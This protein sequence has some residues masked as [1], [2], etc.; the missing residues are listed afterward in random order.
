MNKT[1]I[2]HTQK[3]AE[4][5]ARRQEF[6]KQV[7]KNKVSYTMIAPFIIIFFTFTVLP[8]LMSFF[9]SFTSFDML[10]AP[11]FLGL[12][13][14]IN[15]FLNDEVFLIA[16]KNTF[17]LAVIT[18]P[19]SYVLAFLFA[20]LIHELPKKIRWFMTLVFYAPSISGSAY[21]LWQLIFSSD[22][23]GVLN[24]F[25]IN[26]GIINAPILWL[27]SPQYALIILIIVQLWLSLGVT[28]LA[29]IA[30]LQTVDRTLYEAAAIDGLRNRWQEL[31]FITLPQMKSQLMFGAVMQITNALGIASVSINLLGFPSVEYSG[32]TIVTHLMDFGSTNSTRLEMGYASAIATVLF[33]IML[34][35]NLIVQK[36]IRRVG[37]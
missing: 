8:V 28:F 36:I 14:Y 17:I 21:L 26:L 1:L 31:W 19:V 9:L 18:G 25:L 2:T 11:K 35:S 3:Q 6:W 30:G 29:F 13:N 10:Q 20:W 34:G 12:D 5:R 16:I 24:A 33:F 15:L 23:Y 22:M 27:E 7:K 32:H 37:S 4:R